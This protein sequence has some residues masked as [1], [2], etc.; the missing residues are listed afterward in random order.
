M[1]PETKLW[2]RKKFLMALRSLIWHAD[3]WLHCQEVSLRE[4]IASREATRQTGRPGNVV[5]S[6]CVQSQARH[7]GEPSRI[8]HQET[9]VE[10]EARKS[11][12]AVISKKEARRRREYTNATAFDLRFVR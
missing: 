2:L 1:K 4:E 8:I 7:T 10:W 6:S 5:S 9:F 3:D 12:V 11:G